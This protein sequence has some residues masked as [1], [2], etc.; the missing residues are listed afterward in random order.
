MV[1][2]VYKGRLAAE[3]LKRPDFLINLSDV[4]LNRFRQIISNGETAED[5]VIKYA[6]TLQTAMN[7]RTDQQV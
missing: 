7:P 5:R 1:S 4:Q 6:D 3:N 2:I